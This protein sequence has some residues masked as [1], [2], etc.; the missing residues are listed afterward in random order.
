M[1]VAHALTAVG[2]DVRY[3]SVPVLRETG[4]PRHIARG[5]QELTG[6]ERVLIGELIDGSDVLP[7]NDENVLGRLG[8]NVAKGD[9]AFPLVENVRRNLAPSD[10]AEYAAVGFSLHHRL[11]VPPPE[12]GR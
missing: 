9:E 6:E 8:G 12:F 1:E 2:T 10:P 5:D 11:A 4:T 7:G 3:E